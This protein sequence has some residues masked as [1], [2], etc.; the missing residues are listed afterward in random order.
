MIEA[1]EQFR[2]ADG[3]LPASYEV[4]Y[5]HAWRAENETEKPQQPPGEFTI[6]LDQFGNHN[7]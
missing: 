5:G 7:D 4:V 6:S 3:V 1:Y 2:S